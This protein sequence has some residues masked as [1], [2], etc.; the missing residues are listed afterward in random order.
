MFKD[1]RVVHSIPK[2]RVNKGLKTRLYVNSTM[3][4]IFLLVTG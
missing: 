1:S 2:A 3:I 4:F